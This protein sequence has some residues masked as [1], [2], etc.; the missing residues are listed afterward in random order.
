MPS[1]AQNASVRKEHNISLTTAIRVEE[2]QSI[3]AKSYKLSLN[4]LEL[5]YFVPSIIIIIIVIVM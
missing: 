1:L 3:A 4:V 5:A 2:K